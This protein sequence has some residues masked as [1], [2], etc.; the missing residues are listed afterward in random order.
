MAA[1]SGTRSADG[2]GVSVALE[3]AGIS[4]ATGLAVGSGDG[5]TVGATDGVATAT[6]GG[7]DGIDS[8]RGSTPFAGVHAATTESTKS[9]AGTQRGMVRAVCPDVAG[10]ADDDAGSAGPRRSVTRSW[11][12]LGRSALGQALEPPVAGSAAESDA[13]GG[14][15]CEKTM[16]NRPI[17]PMNRP[18][19]TAV[20]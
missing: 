8:R 2:H 16:A 13:A 17:A 3:V 14:R 15:P 10:T 9:I 20:R 1:G 7:V 11:A 12:G 5:R 6:N 18:S 19:P 4:R